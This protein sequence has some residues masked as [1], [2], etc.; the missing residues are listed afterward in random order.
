MKKRIILVGKSASG[1]DHA[2]KTCEQWFGMTYQVS[3]TTRPPRD[4]E[5]DGLDY[6]FLS[7]NDAI[8]MIK[9]GLFY[10]YVEFNGW[11]YGTTKE[12]FY[13]E[14]SVF[15]MTPSGLSHLSVE[16]RKESFVIYFDIPVD[17]RKA[18]MQE[19][20][21]NADSVN[22]RLEADHIDFLNFENH[23]FMITDPHFKIMDLYQCISPQFNL[24]NKDKFFI[25]TDNSLTKVYNLTS[26]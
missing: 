1:K 5:E 6:N 14:D 8:D 15:I 24:P 16:D 7:Q 20:R 11:L 4:E 10:E 3:Y 26:K 18:R 13:T 12:Q 19:R 2:R 23:D 21:G 17:I 9:R 25:D 22:R